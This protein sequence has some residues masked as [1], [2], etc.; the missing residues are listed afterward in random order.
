MSGSV[1]VLHVGAMWCVEV[2]PVVCWLLGF[3]GLM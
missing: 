1:V 2:V 3:V